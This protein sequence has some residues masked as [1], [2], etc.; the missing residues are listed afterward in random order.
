MFDKIR[1]ILQTLNTQG[2]PIPLAT[3]NGKGSFV[4]S[5]L[6]ISTTITIVSLFE[7]LQRIFGKVNFDNSMYFF[8]VCLG[9]FLG[10]KITNKFGTMEKTEEK[11]DDKV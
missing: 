3:H 2:I 1:K 10:Q 11:K 5:L 4:A 8:V 7:S 6:W 9:G